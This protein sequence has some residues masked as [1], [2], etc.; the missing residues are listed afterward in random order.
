MV[1]NVL[2]K[3]NG[4]P[5]REC[6]YEERERE[7]DWKKTNETD[8]EHNERVK[9]VEPRSVARCSSRTRPCLSGSSLG[10]F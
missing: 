7:R 3:N 8:D 1:R 10:I 2:E 9:D 4:K 5:V 6:V